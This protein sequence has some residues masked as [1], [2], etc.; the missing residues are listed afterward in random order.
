M[1]N[2]GSDA[3]DIS[4]PMMRLNFSKYFLLLAMAAGLCLGATAFT[5]VSA[6]ARST[7]GC[8]GDRPAPQDAEIGRAHV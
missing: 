3:I 1:L 7:P 5:A 2:N 6:T 8:Q 4:E